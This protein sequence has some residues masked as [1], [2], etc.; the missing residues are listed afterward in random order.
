MKLKSFKINKKFTWFVFFL[1]MEF[2]CTTVPLKESIKYENI[3]IIGDK[4]FILQTQRALALLKDKHYKAFYMCQQYLGRIVL[5]SSSGV[6]PWEKT[7]TYEVGKLTA[8]YGLK[9][10]AGTIAHDAF[11]SQLYQEYLMKNPQTKRVP[12]SIWLGKEAEEKCLTYQH[13]VLK[14]LGATL[15]MLRY[16]RSLPATEYWNQ[17]NVYW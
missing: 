17:Q 16:L 11:H 14:K 7:P 8:Y 12:D 10:Y 15:S 6:K 2:A 5:S 3:E 4:N 1:I 9:W 13:Q